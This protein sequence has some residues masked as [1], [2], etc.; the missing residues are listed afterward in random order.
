MAALNPARLDWRLALLLVLVLA[1]M[2]WLQALQLEIS[3]RPADYYGP[4]FPEQPF[5]HRFPENN[6]LFLAFEVKPATAARQLQRLGALVDE[7]ERLPGVDAVLSPLNLPPDLIGDPRMPP[8]APDALAALAG[9]PLARQ[10]LI[11][12]DGGTVG[13]AVRPLRQLA[14][15]DKQRLD[16]QVAEAIERHGLDSS[17]LA[18]SGQVALEVANYRI[19]IRD[20]VLFLACSTLAGSLLLMLIYGRILVLLMTASVILS[21]TGS[22]L[23]L[24]QMLGQPLTLVGAVLPALVASL[25]I[26]LLA[27]WFNS[28]ARVESGT[29]AGRRAAM[30]WRQIHRPALLSTVTTMAGL[31]SLTLSDAAPL[32][33]AGLA[34]AAGVFVQYIHVLWLLPA[35]HAR[36]DHAPWDHHGNAIALLDRI[37]QTTS[38]L[39]L[40]HRRAVLVTAAIATVLLAIGGRDLRVETD[41]LRFFPDDHELI[42]STRLIQ[43]RLAG[44][45]IL[46]L[47]V[48]HD[49]VEGLLEADALHLIRRLAAWMELRPEVDRVVSLADLLDEPGSSAGT[50]SDPAARLAQS[51]LLYSPLQLEELVDRSFSDSRLVV[52]L[53]HAG[54]GETRA[55]IEAFE[56]WLE[57]VDTGRM[58]VAAAGPME[59]LVRFERLLIRGQLW[60]LS[61]AALAIALLFWIAFRRAIDIALCMAMN[62]FPLLVVFAAMSLLAIPLNIATVMVASVM[63]GIAVDDTIHFYHH[64]RAGLRDGLAP[65]CATRRAYQ[66][67][68][69]AMT[70]STIILATE[71][72]LLGISEF[73]PSRQFGLLAAL[74]LIGAWCFDM[75]VLPALV[76][77]RQLSR[78]L[79][80]SRS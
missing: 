54:S 38:T 34:G 56:A 57:T 36:F 22:A 35:L 50:D 28:L 58:R 26:A 67:A 27:H 37:L 45:S 66:R 51:L 17:W 43:Q 69:R 30:A 46:E 70:L 11:A 31:L 59:Q 7:I 71:F 68:G 6:F 24:L 53:E 25:A 23:A 64:F 62:L 21:G 2:P 14:T 16:E 19:T 61:I 12:R 52:H 32:K 41:F 47:H 80:P 13:V 48:S 42:R 63:L 33:S 77:T 4:D 75:L 39:A 60:S 15:R 10:V 1:L 49:R 3:N 44:P 55:L 65:E 5:A 79:M 73:A 20:L 74:G 8:E 72:L 18:R 29:D 76:T 40:R 9:N 78:A